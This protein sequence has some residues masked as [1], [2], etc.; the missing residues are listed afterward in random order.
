MFL[1]FKRTQGR[2]G[3]TIQK[4]EGQL[5]ELQNFCQSLRI[6]GL[7]QIRATTFDAYRKMRKE[8]LCEWSL[9]HESVTVKSWIK[10]CRSRELI[11]E[12]PLAQCRVEKPKRRKPQISPT[13]E[14]LWQILDACR[15]PL[16]SHVATLAFTGMRSGEMRQCHQDDIDFGDSWI[17]V[18]SREETPTKTGE[19]RD[20]PIH[21][22]LL[23][24][25]RQGQSL[26]GPWFYTAEASSRYPNGDH[27]INTK[28]LN[29]RLKTVLK[30]VGL[31]AGRD[32]GF[33]A[34]SLRHF[35]E[36]HCVNAG[37]PQRVVDLWMGHQSDRSMGSQYYDLKPDE[38]QRFMAS[39]DFSRP[40][41][42][43]L[44]D[45]S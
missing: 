4:Y 38:S 14:Q 7:S 5:E 8:S 18:V 9:Y 6:T 35:F 27:W 39:V 16:R 28:K 43:R 13:L 40:T 15:E 33:T 29:D 30:R 19:S 21:P 36:T 31:P 32:N 22:V 34:H 41:T 24:F 3:K 23:P 2:A 37:I 11:R 20:V 25:L 1:D 42:I 26:T 10:W 12:N 44:E 17:H 45:A